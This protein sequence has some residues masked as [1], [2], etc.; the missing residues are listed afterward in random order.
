MTLLDFSRAEVDHSAVVLAVQGE[1]DISNAAEL[2]AALRAAEC[3]GSQALVID[4]SGLDFIDLCG[5]RV[6]ADCQQRR[7][8]AQRSFVV[9]TKPF[10]GE[11]IA[12]LNRSLAP[13][14]TASSLADA[15]RAVPGRRPGAGVPSRWQRIGPCRWCWYAL[16]H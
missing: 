13:V 6:L 1:V 15:L 8:A 16:R 7:R 10:V 9:V 2:D 14:D 5:L 12:L 4:L 11:V 3:S